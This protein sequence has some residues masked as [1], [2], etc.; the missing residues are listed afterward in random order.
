LLTAVALAA[1]FVTSLKTE[2]ASLKTSMDENQELKI[3][4]VDIFVR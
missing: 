2:I 1:S 3:E 4:N